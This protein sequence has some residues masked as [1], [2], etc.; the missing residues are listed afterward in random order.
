MK[1]VCFENDIGNIP[2]LYKKLQIV[3]ADGLKFLSGELEIIDATGKIWDSYK[4]EIKGSSDYPYAFP[5]LFETGNAFP[6]IADWHVYEDTG[7]CCIDVTPNEIII[8]KD[9]LDVAEYIKLY[10]IPYLANQ[11]FRRRE[12]Y[13]LHGEYSHGIV[14]R[15]EFYQSKLRAKDPLQLIEMFDLILKDYNPS[16]T[17]FCP[18]CHKT[19]FRNCHREAFRDL[20]NVKEFLYNDGLQLIPFFKANPDYKLPNI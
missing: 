18:F 17:A 5:Q 4:V 20:Q 7:T 13:Y 3:H 1:N 10:A 15:I 8:C 6:K 12:G 16:R 14:G 9:G 11:T 19:K 2:D